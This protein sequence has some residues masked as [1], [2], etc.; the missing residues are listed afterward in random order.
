MTHCYYFLILDDM[1]DKDRQKL[2]TFTLLKKNFARCIMTYFTMERLEKKLYAD[3][4]S[5]LIH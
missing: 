1:Y 5:N 3:K 2:K 4:L